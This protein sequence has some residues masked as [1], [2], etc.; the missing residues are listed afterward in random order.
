[1]KVEH[2]LSPLAPEGAETNIRCICSTI[3]WQATLANFDLQAAREML[4]SKRYTRKAADE[5]HLNQAMYLLSRCFV[6]VESFHVLRFRNTRCTSS[7]LRPV[8]LSQNDAGPNVLGSWAAQVQL[9]GEWRMIR[10]ALQIQGGLALYAE[11]GDCCQVFFPEREKR[12]L[13]FRT[14]E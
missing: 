6:K 8:C 5:S 12:G 3:S 11:E 4:I 7:F 2:T 10:C 13:P 9:R 14:S 1:M